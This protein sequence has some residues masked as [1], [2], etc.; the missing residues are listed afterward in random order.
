VNRRKLLRQVVGHTL[1]FLLLVACGAPQQPPTPTAVPIPEPTV[2]PTMIA[3]AVATEW[4][5]VAL[6]DS[7]ATCC[8]T[9]SYPDYYAEFIEQDLNIKINLLNLGSSGLA[10][11]ELLGRLGTEHYRDAISQAQVVTV[12]ITMNDLLLCGQGDRECAEEK[13]AASM[14]NYT[15]IIEE[16]LRLTN[17]EDTIIRAQTYD[18][19][20]V[21]EWKERGVFEERRSMLDRWN[22]RIVEIATQ[23][24]I[25]VAM[26]YRDFNGPNG[27]QD[28]GDKGYISTDG[29]HNNDAGA[30]RIAELLREL[31]YEPL[32]P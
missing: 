7:E 3:F 27:D 16:I 8:G 32:A 1:G 30:R 29:M 6:G 14:A 24:N 28:P 5:Y 2:T 21:N 4:L 19:P 17:T 18:N 20:F 10:S 26:V 11:D 15:A 25:P 22:G 9:R 12:V 13:L 31:G 23:Y